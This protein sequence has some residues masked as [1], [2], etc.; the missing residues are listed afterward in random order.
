MMRMRRWDFI[1]NCGSGGGCFGCRAHA[2]RAVHREVLVR[3]ETA[4]IGDGDFVAGEWCCYLGR[5]CR[6]GAGGAVETAGRRAVVKGGGGWDPLV[7]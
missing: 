6:A 4:L 3:S 7:A 1:P 5:C 2:G